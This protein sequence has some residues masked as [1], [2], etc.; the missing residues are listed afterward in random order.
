MQELLVGQDTFLFASDV[1]MP[2]SL[3]CGAGL[4][5]KISTA[6]LRAHREKL[7]NA[8]ARLVCEDK[9][10]LGVWL[11]RASRKG[12]LTEITGRLVASHYVMPSASLLAAPCRKGWVPASPHQKEDARIRT[13][14]QLGILDTP[15]EERFQRITRAV[16][17]KLNVSI[18]LVSLVDTNRQWFKAAT[19]LGAKQT[20]RD[21]AF[22]AHAILGET[23]LIIEDSRE[24]E[25][26]SSNPLVT[27]APTV[28]FYAGVPLRAENGLPLGTLCAIDDK[29]RALTSENLETLLE[30][31]GEAEQELRRSMP[32]AAAAK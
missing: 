20:G 24:D 28:I 13:L 19:G 29:P 16:S 6:D 26:F 31:A 8:P 15:Q 10:L 11:F 4:R 14:Q 5:L 32:A 27:G 1:E 9:R 17:E 2:A 12:V 18:S 3:R 30:L 21:E 7:I 23:P 22:C 25:R